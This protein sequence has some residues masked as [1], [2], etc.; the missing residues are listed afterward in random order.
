M[1][2]A[3]ISTC[4]TAIGVCFAAWQIMESRIIARTQFEDILDAQYRS[5]MQKIPA[6]VF[7]ESNPTRPNKQLN[8]LFFNYYDLSN[9]QIFLRQ[10]GR[11]SDSRW[12]C[13]SE[14]IRENMNLKEIND[15]WEVV[16]AHDKSTDKTR[17]TMLSK[18]AANGY[19]E[20]PKNW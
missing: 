2:V 14:G 11:I 8:E 5:L 3:V 17:F 15:F 16:I 12:E 7:L 6:D 4:L 1:I 10:Q 9:E 19:C 18:F 13:W 20:D